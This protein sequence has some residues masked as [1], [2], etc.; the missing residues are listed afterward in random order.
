[1]DAKS[2]EDTWTPFENLYEGEEIKFFVL[3]SIEITKYI[4]EYFTLM[5]WWGWPT[6]SLFAG[7]YP[8]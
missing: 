6:S 3:T 2:N 1:M 4:V 8:L 7:F 5:K